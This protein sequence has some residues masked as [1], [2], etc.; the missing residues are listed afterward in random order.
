MES[1]FLSWCPACQLKLQYLDCQPLQQC[2]PIP[3]LFLTLFPVLLLFL[4]RT[5]TKADLGKRVCLKDQ[6]LKDQFSELVLIRSRSTM[7]L[8]L[9]VKRAL[10]IPGVMWQW[11]DVEYHHQI[12]R[13]KSTE[14][15][16]L[17][18]YVYETFKHYCQVNLRA[19]VSHVKQEQCFLSWHAIVRIQEYM[20]DIAHDVHSLTC[21]PITM[22]LVTGPK[23]LFTV[24]NQA[25]FINYVPK[26]C[27][28]HGSSVVRSINT[29]VLLELNVC[30]R[31]KKRLE[32]KL[33]TLYIF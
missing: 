12:F 28:G 8:F 22:T 7:T 15:K 30:I 16:V 9:A 2:E 18:D 21:K 26:H 24:L 33:K 13:I 11:S 4:W 31:K 3:S 32:I 29:S 25:T 1:Q 23:L 19:L 17:G 14:G 5:P 20:T 6:N 10:I 27:S